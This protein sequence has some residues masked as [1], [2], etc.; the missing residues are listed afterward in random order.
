MNEFIDSLQLL[1]LNGGYFVSSN[2]RKFPLKLEHINHMHTKL[3]TSVPNSCPPN[4]FG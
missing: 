4:R 2:S 3:G 1:G